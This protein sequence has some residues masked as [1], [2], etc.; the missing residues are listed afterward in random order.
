MK[1]IM[2]R[3]RS[4]IF[5]M[6]ILGFIFRN[7][8]FIFV[9]KVLVLF[10]F[11]YAISYGFL[12]Q[13][14]EEN[15]FTTGVFLNL[16]WPFFMV[17][18]LATLGRMYC[19]ICPHGFIGKYITKIGLKKK[20]PKLMANPFIGLSLLVFG[21]WFVFYMWPNLLRTPF[22]IALMFTVL[23]VVAVVV[24]FV[25]D[26]MSYCKYICPIGTLTKAFSKNGFTKLE[27]YTDGCASCK[28]FDC[29]KACSYNLKPFTFNRKNSME[30]CTLCMDCTSACDNVAFKFVKP[31]SNLFGKFKINKVEVWAI[32]VITA[33][34]S[35]AMTMHHA[36]GRT[37]IADEFIWHKTAV[38][39]QSIINF[40]T[41]NVEAFFTL[42]YALG[43]SIGITVLGMY[44]A[45][46]IMKVS[47][48]KTFYTLGYAFAPLFIIGGLAHICEFFFF[49]YASNIVNGFIQ[50]FS[51]DMEYIKPLASRKDKWVMVFMAFTHIAYIWAFIIMIGRLKLIDTKT[52]LK[53]LAFPFASALIIFYMCL[54]FYTGYV[55]QTYGAKKGGHNHQAM[56][57]KAK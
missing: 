3:H 52:S 2:K 19:G 51:L 34:L 14:K 17:V 30:D 4:D 54:K 36:L 23:T 10:L 53:V 46:R 50:A 38:Y 39:F 26:N 12:Y 21:W 57:K 41:I 45:S 25:Y 37:A 55:F 7:Q 49:A 35:I 32:I 16:F 29:A 8:N 33:I 18:S 47:Y 5:S 22:A 31:S 28:S 11:V 9:L 44:I 27:T 20:M 1:E 56:I 48:E 43:M 24:Y 42:L 15:K 6:P 40:G 13:T